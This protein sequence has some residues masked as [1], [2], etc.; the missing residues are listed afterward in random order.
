MDAFVFNNDLMNKLIAVIVLFFLMAC[1]ASKNVSVVSANLDDR[2]D[3]KK[4]YLSE[5]KQSQTGD[6]KD[7]TKINTD[8][9]FTDSSRMDNIVS[10]LASDSLEG[11]DSGSAGISKAAD[12]IESLFKQ[13]NLEPYFESYRDTLSNFNGTA[14]NMVGLVPGNN[15]KLA[16]EYIIIGAHYDHIGIVNSA[17]EDKIANG[18]NDNASGTATV[19]ELARYF[20][21]NGGNKRSIMF[22]LFS[23]EEKG[24]LGSAHLAGVLKEQDLKLYTMLNFEMTGVPLQGRDYLMFL[25]GYELSN[26]AELCNQYAG[27]KLV[28]FLMEARHYQ[29]FRRSDNFP[30]HQAFGVPSQ[31]YC[32]FDFTNYDYYHKVGDEAYRLNYEHMATL[33]NKMIPV[34]KGLSSAEKDELKYY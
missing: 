27:E 16:D 6:N 23:A 32:T 5:N 7:A 13:Y 2:P 17:T 24:L 33:V 4:A 29:L 25:T 10:F 9:P 30:F 22:V 19:L 26:L 14:F 12:Y 11:R 18:A 20:G 28:G 3:G 34:I 15:K 21:L 1:G 31:T 8:A